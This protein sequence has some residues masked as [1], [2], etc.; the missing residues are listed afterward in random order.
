MTTPTR[1]QRQRWVEKT[2]QAGMCCRCGLRPRPAGMVRCVPCTDK[3][4]LR[5]RRKQKTTGEN[6]H[7]SMCGETGHNRLT[8][9]AR[10][11]APG[12]A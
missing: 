2:E 10:H 4:K 1:E 6:R 7:C 3:E 12:A 9:D 5:M 8:C 11:P